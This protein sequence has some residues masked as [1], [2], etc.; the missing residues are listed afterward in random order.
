[1]APRG[2]V[3]PQGLSSGCSQ[4]VSW[5]RSLLDLTGAGRSTSEFTQEA[6]DGS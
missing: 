4:S 5:T 3:L 6:V 1:M 2:A